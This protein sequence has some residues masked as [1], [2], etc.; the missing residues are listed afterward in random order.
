[1]IWFTHSNKI[2]ASYDSLETYQELLLKDV[3]GENYT[4]HTPINPDYPG[5]YFITLNAPIQRVINGQ[6]ICVFGSYATN[7]YGANPVLIYYSSDNFQSIKVAYKFGKNPKYRDNG[8]P[9]QETSGNLVG[10]SSNPLIVRHVHGT[11]YDDLSD[12]WV[13]FTGDI[14]EENLLLNGKYDSENDSWAWAKYHDGAS[15]PRIKFGGVCSIME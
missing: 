1:M 6:D 7:G 10:D 3:D 12:T 2:Y 9:N 14:L 4:F 8:G 11:A 15:D 13:A 5:S